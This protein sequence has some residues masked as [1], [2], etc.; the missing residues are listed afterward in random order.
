MEK[1]DSSVKGP[2]EE[3]GA[4]DSIYREK[5]QSLW[6]VDSKHDELLVIGL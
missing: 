1:E 6:V 3:G 2:D 4:M 5:G